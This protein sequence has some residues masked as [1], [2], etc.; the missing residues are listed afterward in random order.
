MKYY[1]QS[2]TQEQYILSEMRA[3][4]GST[5]EMLAAINNCW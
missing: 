4:D 1:P 3:L 5:S 2:N